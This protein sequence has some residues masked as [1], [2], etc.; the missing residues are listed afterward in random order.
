MKSNAGPLE[1]AKWKRLPEVSKC[2]E[3]LFK[4]MDDNEENSPLIITRIVEKA[5]LRKDYSNTEFA[6]AIAI[7]KII[8]NPKDDTLQMKESIIKSKVKYYLVGLFLYVQ[9]NIF[10]QLTLVFLIKRIRLIK[11]YHW[12]MMMI[13]IVTLIKVAKNKVR[14]CTEFYFLL[15]YE[16]LRIYLFVYFYFIKVGIILQIG[17]LRSKMLLS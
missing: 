12:L 6:Y 4:K 10:Y 13:T 17:A 5:F 9:V 11:N 2:Y 1:I 14:T 3:K 8:L 16:S 15:I 7:C